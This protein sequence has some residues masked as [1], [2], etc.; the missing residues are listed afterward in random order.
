MPKKSGKEAD[1]GVSPAGD[2]RGGRSRL[3][4]TITDDA[5]QLSSPH[6]AS[7]EADSSVSPEKAVLG[8][9]PHSRRGDAGAAA[10]LEGRASQG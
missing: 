5:G 2:K 6:G 4:P 3:E 8:R 9:R 1:V 7:R 10:A